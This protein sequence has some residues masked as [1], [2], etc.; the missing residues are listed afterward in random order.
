MEKAA[1]NLVLA[2]IHCGIDSR[3]ADLHVPDPDQIHYL[4]TGCS[5]T[6]ALLA[7]IDLLVR[8]ADKISRQVSAV[9]YTRKL[10]ENYLLE[11]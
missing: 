7:V 2:A 3:Q 6:E 1:S 11:K 4:P 10:G 8:R 5:A 9:R